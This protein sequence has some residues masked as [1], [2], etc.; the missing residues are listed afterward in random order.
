MITFNAEANGYA[1][2]S[3]EEALKQHPDF[4][5][6]SGKET[7]LKD[8]SVNFNHHRVGPRATAD[9][10]LTDDQSEEG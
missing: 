4:Q 7:R 6:A 1:D 5:A 2:S 8:G 10:D 3:A 9:G